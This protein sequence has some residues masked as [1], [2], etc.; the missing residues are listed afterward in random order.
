MRT[1]IIIPAALLLSI[2]PFLNPAE[3]ALPDSACVVYRM[4]NPTVPEDYPVSF[5]D[6]WGAGFCD[7]A[8]PADIDTVCA[9]EGATVA[10]SDDDRAQSDMNY[11]NI[12][13]TIAA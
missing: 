2:G 13:R 8:W 1:N 3:Q 12:G 7:I 4:C 9:T 10:L 5:E 6:E 11:G